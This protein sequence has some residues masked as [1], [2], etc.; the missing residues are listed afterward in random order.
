MQKPNMLNRELPWR[1]A[2][3][4]LI[5]Q[6]ASRRRRIVVISIE[7]KHWAIHYRNHRCFNSEGQH[8]EPA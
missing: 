6:R 1:D 8:Y 7:A 5:Q 2:L 4:A 3:V